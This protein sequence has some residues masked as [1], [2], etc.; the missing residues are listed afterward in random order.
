MLTILAAGLI[1]TVLMIALVGLLVYLIVTYIQMPAIFKTVIQIVCVVV[2]ILWL[3][4]QFG[5]DI[6]L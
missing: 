3:I 2:L 6:P 1:H 4:K 5:G